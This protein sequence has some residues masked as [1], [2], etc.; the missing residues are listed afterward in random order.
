[1]G[2]EEYND[3][4]GNYDWHSGSGTQ[5]ANPGDSMP[6]WE[7]DPYAQPPTGNGDDHAADWAQ[8]RNRPGI[9]NQTW[10]YIT[11]PSV[12]NYGGKYGFARQEANRYGD[13]ANAA[14]SR[15]AAQIDN[16]N[17]FTDRRMEVGA[18]GGRA[19][20]QDALSRYM[21][22][23]TGN[24]PSVANAQ[25]NQAFAQNRAQAAGLAANARG[26]G[27]NLAFAQR[28]GADAAAAGNSGAAGQAM[29]ARGQ[30]QLGALGGYTQIASQQR[31]QDLQRQGLS[32][33][34]AFRQAQLEQQQHALN[35]ARNL[36][37]EGLRKEV[38]EDQAHYAQ[39][40]EA[41]NAAAQAK[42]AQRAF[43]QKQADRDQN[44]KLITGATG[45]VGGVVGAY[46]GGP[47]G[48]AAGAKIGSDLGDSMSSDIRLK[49]NI[50]PGA[51]ETR[52]LLDDYLDIPRRG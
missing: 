17:Y 48:A 43:Q 6:G 52:L 4:T 36:A 19:A 21:D 16:N 11:N 5:Y 27:A 31:A 34:Q 49:K 25:M 33:E 15:Q 28:A 46:A 35:D 41:E 30:E 23:Y 13:I 20:Q 18:M 32:A 3:K 29:T 14:D 10:D 50:R 2:W 44:N 47:A 45:A 12:Y 8:G 1:M 24:G 38:F 37:Y 7:G 9:D 51:A 22:M 42:N 39:A 40:G 26:G